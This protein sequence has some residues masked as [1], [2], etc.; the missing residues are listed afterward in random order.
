MRASAGRSVY[1][2]ADIISVAE[3]L[4]PVSG[5]RLRES[6]RN[7]RG[8]RGTGRDSEK[9]EK[10]GD[11]WS[12]EHRFRVTRNPIRRA[13]CPSRCSSLSLLL[14]FSFARWR[15]RKSG[16]KDESPRADILA[17]PFF[18]LSRP[19]SFFFFPRSPPPPSRSSLALTPSCSR[20]VRSASPARGIGIR[21]FEVKERATRFPT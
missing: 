1:A 6:C 9:R 15:T 18:R 16:R 10:E 7:R 17:A 21:D 4:I 8:I 20:E 13:I 19:R 2:N 14:S 5:P 3:I 12:L 11:N